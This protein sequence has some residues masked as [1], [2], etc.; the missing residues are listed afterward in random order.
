LATIAA[1]AGLLLAAGSGVAWVAAVEQP[2]VIAGA[3][4]IAAAHLINLFNCRC[5][6]GA[7]ACVDSAP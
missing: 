4:M 3:G 5:R 6:K 7:A 1:G 2:L